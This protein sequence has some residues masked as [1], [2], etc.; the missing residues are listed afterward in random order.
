MTNLA[1]ELVMLSKD[2]LDGLVSDMWLQRP[3]EIDFISEADYYEELDRWQKEMR[4]LGEAIDQVVLFENEVN[5]IGS[6]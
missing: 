4:K 5:S 1:K 2:E 3:L 6:V